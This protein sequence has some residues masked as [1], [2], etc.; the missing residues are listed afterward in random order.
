MS[1]G[2][3]HPIKNDSTQWYVSNTRFEFEFQIQRISIPVISLVERGAAWINE[4]VI[5]VFW[6]LIRWN[7]FYGLWLCFF[8]WAIGAIESHFI[9]YHFH[10]ISMLKTTT[11][12]FLIAFFLAGNNMQKNFCPSYYLVCFWIEWYIGVKVRNIKIDFKN[13]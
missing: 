5:P 1:V 8:S 7:P 13:F 6:I 10:G 3:K 4:Y 9:F 11:I 12:V 2:H